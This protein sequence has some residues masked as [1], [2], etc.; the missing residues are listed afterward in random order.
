MTTMRTVNGDFG[1]VDLL[2]GLGLTVFLG[3]EDRWPTLAGL[4]PGEHLLYYVLFRSS[5]TISGSH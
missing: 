4:Q 2:P 1:R 5:P 3:T